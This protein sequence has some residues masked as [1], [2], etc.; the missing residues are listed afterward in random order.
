MK[1]LV[2][3]C[4]GFIG[5]HLCERLI[6][7]GFEV[8]G[9]DCLSNYYPVWIKLK[10]LENLK[11]EKNFKFLRSKL[12]NLNLK[13]ILKQIDY[14][15]H[16]AAQPGVRKSWGNDFQIYAEANI[17]ATQKLL[18]IAKSL[19]LKK[20]IFASSSS[21]YG[22]CPDL[23]MKESSPLFPLSPYGV[24]KLAAEKL[25][26][27]YYK[28]FN[29][30]IISLRYFTVYGPRQRPDM[31]FHKFMKSILFNEEII[32]FGDGNQTRDFTY[33]DDVV[34]ATLQ[35][36][37]NGK[38]G[39]IYNIGGGN[40]IKINDVL[41]LLEEIT[42]KKIKY[43]NIE[44]QKGEMLHT[45]ALINKAKKDLNFAPKTN[46]QEGLQKEWN[47]LQKIYTSDKDF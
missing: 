18:E 41:Y 23:P 37:F 8:I 20:F 16:L 38:N 11:K 45:L 7:E 29:L 22:I 36:A 9:I 43:K 42:K 2:T 44:A 10:N 26:F 4:A 27:L 19:S 32:I 28:N 5:S 30:P 31:A 14:I 12:E 1:C 6:K 17:L 39:E 34:E 47:W 21:V 40:Q 46:L 25:C 3:G 13:E 35:A 24:T 15:F 33:I